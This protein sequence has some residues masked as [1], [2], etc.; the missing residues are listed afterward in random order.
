MPRLSDVAR[1]V[2]TPEGIVSTGWPAVEET[3]RVMGVEF[4]EWQRGLGKLILAKRGDGLF[5]ADIMLMSIPRQ[6]G[7]TYLL[8]GVVF[9][10]CCA[11]AHDGDLDGAPDAYGGGDVPV[12]AGHRQP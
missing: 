7:K 12:D 2:V 5:A 3:C 9:A 10:M 8:G 6:S 1:H 4:D 11:A